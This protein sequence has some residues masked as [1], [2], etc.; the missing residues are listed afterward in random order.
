MRRTHLPTT[1]VAALAAA[2]GRARERASHP[3]SNAIAIVLADLSPKSPHFMLFHTS[4]GL[5][6]GT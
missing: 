4:S 5:A 1:L 3:A 2:P 6:A